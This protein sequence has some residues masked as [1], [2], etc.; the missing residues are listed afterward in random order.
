M[1]YCVN[2]GVQLNEKASKCPLCQTPVIKPAHSTASKQTG[3]QPLIKEYSTGEFD[4]SL[5][6]KLMSIT[7]LSPVLITILIDRL[8]SQNISWSLYV[9]ACLVFVWTWSISPFFFNKDRFIKWIPVGTI[10][11]L[12][13]LFSIENISGT[14]GWFL[15]IGMPITISFF[16]ISAMLSILIRNQIVRELQIPAA[17]LIAIGIFCICINGAINLHTKGV[18]SFD[19]ALIVMSTCIAFSLIGF[20]L[21]QRP[22]IVEELRHWFRM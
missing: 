19:W 13:F 9:S 20:V 22:W 4:R 2:C 10:T 15:T 8:F 7:L 3:S 5:W 1:T 17:I 21:Q 16:L 6:I 18:I 12:G 14:G 11:M